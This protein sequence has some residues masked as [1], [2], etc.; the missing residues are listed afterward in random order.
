MLLYPEGGW[1][2]LSAKLTCL[3]F[4]PPSLHT[5]PNNDAYTRGSSRPCSPVHQDMHSKL[6]SSPPRCSPVR[7]GPSYI[8]KK[9]KVTKLL[10]LYVVKHASLIS[11]WQKSE[12][13]MRSGGASWLNQEVSERNLTSAKSSLGGHSPSLSPPPPLFAIW[14]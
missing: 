4:F 5:E 2:E 12:L 1:D 8:L 13:G 3:D 9:G 14:G 6:S 7:L 10:A 11:A